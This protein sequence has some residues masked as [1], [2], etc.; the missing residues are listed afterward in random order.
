MPS[1][2]RDSGRRKVRETR[3]L[4]L[5]SKVLLSGKAR[6]RLH[7]KGGISLSEAALYA[8]SP[9]ESMG[10]LVEVVKRAVLVI[11]KVTS[12]YEKD[13]ESGAL[14]DAAKNLKST[15]TIFVRKHKND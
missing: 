11:K 5:Y 6:S 15:A 3:E 7:A 14:Q 2:K 8:D 9:R 10:Q 13:A 1:G 4:S 12:G